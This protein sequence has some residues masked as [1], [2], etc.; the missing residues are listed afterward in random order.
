MES[1][2]DLIHKFDEAL[3]VITRT[4]P[5]GLYTFFQQ[6]RKEGFTDDQSMQLTL[7]FFKLITKFADIK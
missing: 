3:T 4:Y 1:F 2:E 7:E 5:S 6:C